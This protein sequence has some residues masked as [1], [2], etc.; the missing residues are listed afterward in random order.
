MRP[1]VVKTRKMHIGLHG[2]PWESVNSYV[3][4]DEL[5][6]IMQIEF[7][8]HATALW[9]EASLRQFPER[10]GSEV[11]VKWDGEY[12]RAGRTKRSHKIAVFL[13]NLKAK[14]GRLGIDWSTP[15]RI[16]VRLVYEE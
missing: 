11:W 15:T 16:F 13:L 10:D 1:K 2:W 9:L 14:L 8:S 6:R 5:V 12:L 3:C 7:P 4:T